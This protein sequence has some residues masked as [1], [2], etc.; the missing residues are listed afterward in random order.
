M[1]QTLSSLVVALGYQKE[2]EVLE[3]V[4]HGNRAPSSVITLFPVQ[5][6]YVDE[7]ITGPRPSEIVAAV[8]S[9][10]PSHYRSK[11]EKMKQ[12]IFGTVK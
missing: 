11:N 8:P 5:T 2:Q 7:Y 12:R 1:S 3:Q 10:V 9:P 4:R 6:T